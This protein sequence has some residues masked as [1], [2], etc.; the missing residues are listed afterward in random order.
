LQI[1]YLTRVDYPHTLQD[2]ES[3][4]PLHHHAQWLQGDGYSQRQLGVAKRTLRKSELS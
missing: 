2:V 3:Y 4:A 1:T